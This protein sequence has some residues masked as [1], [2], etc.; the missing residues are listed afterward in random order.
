MA[1]V[2]VT[3]V[4]HLRECWTGMINIFVKFKRCLNW[5]WANPSSRAMVSVQDV[6]KKFEKW[7]R[8]VVFIEEGGKSVCRNILHTKMGVPKEGAKIYEYLQCC[9]TEIKKCELLPFQENTLFPN[10]RLLDNSK[11]DLPLFTYIIQILDENKNYPLIKDLRYKRNELFH[12]EETRKEVC[13]NRNSRNIGMRC[14]S[15]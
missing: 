3:S 11:L 13:V 10:D 15:C 12:M 1:L 2:V 6:G 7:C 5:Y 14:H 4:D 8:L 9:K